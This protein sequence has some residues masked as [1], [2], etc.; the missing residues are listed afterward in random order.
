MSPE[1]NR[2]NELFAASRADLLAIDPTTLERPRVTRDRALY[3]TAAL[4][5]E[6]QPLLPV[7]PDVLAPAQVAA[8]QADYQAVEPRVL[9]FYAA[10]MAVEQPWSS[11]QKERRAEL[12]RKVRQHDEMLSAWA[13]PAFRQD[14]EASAEVADILRGRGMRD[15]AEDTVR[16]VA[17][18]RGRCSGGK[19]SRNRRTTS[20]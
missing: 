4:R 18:F 11:E 9:V 3:L 13:V 8:R 17:L 1:P 5:R 14:E 19:S 20:S 16:L 12:A 15:D 10:D 7:L 6:F 2:I